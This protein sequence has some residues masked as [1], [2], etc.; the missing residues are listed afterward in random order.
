MAVLSLVEMAIF[1]LHRR[2]PP[3]LNAGVRL[4]RRGGVDARCCLVL[5]ESIAPHQVLECDT[6]EC[7]CDTM[8]I[9]DFDNMRTYKN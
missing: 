4:I 1:F 8:N 5:F 6:M 2:E 7:Y 9:E 3:L